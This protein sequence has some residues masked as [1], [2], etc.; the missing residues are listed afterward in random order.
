MK[1][2][3]P[4]EQIADAVRAIF[5]ARGSL[6]DRVAS[7]HAELYNV[8]KDV[9][10]ENFSEGLWNKFQELCNDG[11]R[12]PKITEQE[13]LEYAYE[14]VEFALLYEREDAIRDFKERQNDSH[15]H[16]RLT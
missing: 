4:A 11:R 1:S 9:Y 12:V 7:A 16:G 8:N 15:P 3:Y 2:I 13:L 10:A 5:L 14:I 6:Q